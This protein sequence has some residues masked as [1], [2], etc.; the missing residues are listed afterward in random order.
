MDE[1]FRIAD[2]ATI[3]RDGKHIITAP[4]SRVHA[5]IDDRAYHRPTL[6]R[7]LRRGARDGDASASA[8]LEAARPVGRRASRVEYRSD[9]PPRRGGRA[10]PACSAAA[11]RRWRACSPGSSRCVSGEIRIKGKPVAIAKPRDAIDAGIALVPE[12]RAAAGFRRLPFGREPTSTCPIL[13]RLSQDAWVRS[14]PRP[15]ALADS[16]I[17]RLRIKT[18]SRKATVRTL[19]GGNAQKVVIAKWLATEPEVL[20]LD[21]PTAG[22]DIGSKA[23]IVTLIRDLAKSRQGDP[24]AVVGAA[25]A[26]RRLRPHPG[27]VGRPHRPRHR[28]PRPRRRRACRLRSTA[29]QHAEQQL[30][31]FMQEAREEPCPMTD[32]ASCGQQTSSALANWREYI[33]YIGFVADLPRLRRDAGRQGLSRPQQPAQHHPPDRDDRDHVGGDD[34]CA[35]R[36]ARSTSRSARSPAS[37]RSRPPWRSTMFGIARRDRLRARHRRRRRRRQRLADHRGSAFP[38]S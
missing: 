22:I 31:K 4:M 34:L 24:G 15:A 30:N 37:P 14:Q 25:G 13:D 32:T 6:A 7:L 29:L 9:A 12:D 38:R 1:I 5:G 36:P 16:S 20:I 21:E 28:P 19:S 18:D 3:L 33:I 35:L 23:E 10:S 17:Q 27:D 8:L 11:A 26:A 2:R